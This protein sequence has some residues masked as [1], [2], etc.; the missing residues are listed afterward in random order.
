MG[1]MESI[2]LVND[3]LRVPLEQYFSEHTGRAWKVKESKDMAEFACHPATILS[4]GSFSVFEKSSDAIYGLEQFEIEIAGIRLLSGRSG[5]F[6]TH[7]DRHHFS[8]RR[9]KY[10]GS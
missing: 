9:R 2:Q 7:S 4:D 5:V 6:Y 10:P 1:E 3:S 8:S